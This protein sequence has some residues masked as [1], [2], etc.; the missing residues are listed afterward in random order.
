[1]DRT[2]ERG[3]MIL[4]LLTLATLFLASAIIRIV[5][6]PK[7]RTHYREDGPVSIDPEY[8]GIIHIKSRSNA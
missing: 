3:G 5:R 4:A 8:R 6:R 7:T 2:N 1:M